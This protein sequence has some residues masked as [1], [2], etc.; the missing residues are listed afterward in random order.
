M[1]DIV[2]MPWLVIPIIVIVSVLTVAMV[3]AVIRIVPVRFKFILFM[4][5]II[6]KDI[7]D[8][9]YEIFQVIIL[10]VDTRGCQRVY[11]DGVADRC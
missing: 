7:V 10:T 9:F 8:D 1:F 6:L 2:G 11:V 5:Q 3:A 4:R